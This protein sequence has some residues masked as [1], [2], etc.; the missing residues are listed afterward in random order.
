MTTKLIEFTQEQKSLIWNTKVSPNKGNEQDVKAFISVCE[1]YGLNPLLGDI[2]FQKFETKYGPRVS[3]LITRDAY[4]KYAMRQDDFQNLLSGVVKE[5]DQFEVDAVEGVPIHKFGEKRGKIVGA[6]AVVKSKT[7]GNT[8]KFADYQEYH[9]AL[10]SKNPVWNSMP[11]AMITKVAESMALKTTFPLG[12]V[13]SSDD[14]VVGLTEEPKTA[15]PVVEAE[16]PSQEDVKAELEK[17]KKEA[18]AKEAAKAKAEA[19][20]A[21]KALK[22]EQAKAEK[23]EKAAA[24]KAEKATPPA[25][26]EPTATTPE[27]EPQKEEI[28]EENKQA[29]PTAEETPVE[30]AKTSEEKQPVAEE[31]KQEEVTPKEEVVGQ[32][33][34]IT[35]GNVY[36]FVKGVLGQSGSGSKFLRVYYLDNGQQ[37]EAFARDE[38]IEM[39]DEFEEGITFKG[40]FQEVNGFN[41]VL[42]AQAV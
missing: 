28:A 6:W 16:T 22:E 9:S 2:V 42:S 10:S 40:N 24:E 36:Q 26:E 11:S 5:G 8:F 19:K 12:V 1:E 13:F 18:A 4:L 15:E 33:E 14:D 37:F 35:E 38:K 27:E 25:P 21:E 32:E 31:T 20:K 29:E 39:F 34:A 3:Y 30:E 41:F 7:R 17:A 23:A